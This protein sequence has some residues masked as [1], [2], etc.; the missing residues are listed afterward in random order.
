MLFEFDKTGFPLIP[1]F[2][3]GSYVQLLPVTKKQFE[4]F[5][6]ED[7]RWVTAYAAACSQH[8]E[9]EPKDDLFLESLFITGVLPEEIHAFA[10]WL[11]PEGAAPFRILDTDTWREVYRQIDLFRCTP[12]EILDQCEVTEVRDMLQHIYT[13][14]EPHTLLDMSLMRKG[15]IEW[16]K[17][18]ETYAGLGT[19]RREF[20]ATTLADPLED[21]VF[22]VHMQRRVRTFGFRLIRDFEPG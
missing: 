17:E 10:D 2:D 21:I 9:R 14:R 7:P 5:V 8:P 3:L 18:D 4:T 20:W 12:E 19:P 6:E 1:L 13:L 15:L 11:T 22:P 16:V